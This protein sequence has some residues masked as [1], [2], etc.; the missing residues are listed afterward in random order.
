M[1]EEDEQEGR[2]SVAISFGDQYERSFVRSRNLLT[3]EQYRF[4]IFG[5]HY[6]SSESAKDRRISKRKK[7][8]VESKRV[9][10]KDRSTK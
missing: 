9:D 1:Y 10:A 2:Q 6:V 3:K 7:R 4:A 5:F 8:R